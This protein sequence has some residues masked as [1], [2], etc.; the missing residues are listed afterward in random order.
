MIFTIWERLLFWQGSLRNKSREMFFI[1]FAIGIFLTA[2]GLVVHLGK[3]Y[4]WIAGYNTM[5]EVDKEI[6]DI[7]KFARHFG[8]AL[9]I[10]GIGIM[11]S[12]IVFQCLNIEAAYSVLILIVMVIGCVVYLNMVE[13]VIERN[14][15]R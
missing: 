4:N 8:I 11:I 15:K 3:K 7:E 13:W 5:D 9:Y 2:I 6:F 12:S 14:P 10:T 1:N